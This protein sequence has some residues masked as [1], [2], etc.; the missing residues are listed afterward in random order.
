[1]PPIFI[2]L[3]SKI[4][5]TIYIRGKIGGKKV[6]GLADRQATKSA[7]GQALKDLTAKKGFNKVSVGDITT[8]CGL[9]R[10]S[11]YY[12]FQDK[13]QL[14]NWV[15]DTQAFAPLNQETQITAC[16]DQIGKMLQIIENDKRFYVA[17]AKAHPDIFLI[18]I[19]EKLEPMFCRI[20]SQLYE[21]SE[22]PED[23]RNFAVEFYAMGLSAM[24]TRWAKNGMRTP[25]AQ[26]AKDIRQ[27]SQDSRQA[28]L[29]FTES[30]NN[31]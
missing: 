26:M 2:A 14:L 15:F 20:A 9:G 12:H 28:V 4:M 10:Q 21:P 1:M 11:F 6:N 31:D 3:N 19:A 18:T 8:A 24:I 25:A 29:R 13:Y 16:A 27:M 30:Q 5:Y 7:L 23:R 17:V 22:L